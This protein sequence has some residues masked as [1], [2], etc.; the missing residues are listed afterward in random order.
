MARISDAVLQQIKARLL[1][2][3]V[4]SEYVRLTPRGGRLWGLCPF[5]EEKTP[6]FSVVDDQGFY[7]CFSCKKGG[8]MFDFIMEMEKIPFADAVRTLG[9]RANVQVEEESDEDRKRRDLRDTLADLYDKLSGSFHYI[10]TS[11]PMGEKARSYLQRRGVDPAMWKTFNLGYAPSDSTWLHT[12]LTERHYSDDL[13]AQSGLF[14]KKN[15]RYPLF[16]DRLMF[17]I[18]TWQGKCIAFG[19]RDLSDTS[20][21]KYINTPETAIYSKKHNL[22]GIYES[23]DTIKREE[24]V[25]ICEGNFDVIALHQSGMQRAMA[26]LGTSFTIE[27]AKLIARYAAKIEV[28]FDNDQAGQNALQKAL[29]MAQQQGLESRVLTLDG[30]KDPADVVQ[31][32]GSSALKRM[33]EGEGVPAFRYLVQSAVNQYDILTSKGKSA[34]FRVVRPYLDATHSAIERQSLVQELA[35][36]LDVDEAAILDDYSQGTVT[37]TPVAEPTE[38]RLVPLNPA[39]ITVDYYALLTL[40]N[41]RELFLRTRQKLAVEQ[42]EDKYA[43]ALYDVLEEAARLGGEKADESILQ[44]IDDPQLYSDVAASFVMEEFTL[45]PQRVL[46]EAITRIQLRQ[47]E[48]RRHSNKRLLDIS[49]HDGTEFS[50]IEELL[51]EKTEIDMRISELRRTLERE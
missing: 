7:Y 36:V 15:P 43:E 3:E 2:S 46:N 8:S 39:A 44:M 42:L 47:Y 24:R 25:I 17:P 18:R 27:Q 32:E 4:V 35:A 34:V 19:G 37:T 20:K 31:Q 51:R 49:L 14:S 48:R 1:L 12:F 29:V 41:N 38:E 40:V 50:E 26:P 9:R 5:H 10:L 11:T 30:A 21:A 16:V 6:S 13:L 22:Y 23:L 45:D 33:L 28:L